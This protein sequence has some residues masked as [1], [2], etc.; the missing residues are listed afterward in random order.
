M[1]FPF[2]CNPHSMSYSDF[3]QQKLKRLKAVRDF[4]EARLAAVD[5][6]I[7]T[8]ERQ[9]ATTAARSDSAEAA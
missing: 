8:V 7:E 1:F 4:L 2:C 9:L 3:K 6:E 5:A